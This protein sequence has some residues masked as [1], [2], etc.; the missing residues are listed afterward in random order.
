MKDEFIFLHDRYDLQDLHWETPNY[1]FYIY[2]Y[3]CV[4]YNYNLSQIQLYFHHVYIAL[5][6]LLQNSFSHA[7][8][9]SILHPS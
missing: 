4:I 2:V 9:H 6:I 7:T 8:N 3:N 5:A 1:R